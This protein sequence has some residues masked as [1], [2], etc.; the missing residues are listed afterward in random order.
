MKKFILFALI[1]LF[2][3]SCASSYVKISPETIN[4]TSSD[5][6]DS[7]KVEYKYG[8][9]QKKY[10]KKEYKKGIKVIAIKVTNN[11]ER[12]IT[13][14][15]NLNFT[16]ANGEAFYLL[17]DKDIFKPL[18][19]NVA[20]Y[21]LYLLLTPINFYTYETN[22]YGQ[23]E[24]TSSTPIGLVVGPGVTA[25]N[26]ITAASANKKFKTE[27]AEY[28]LVGKTIKTGE[29]IHGIIGVREQGF[30]NINIE[31]KD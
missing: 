3:T 31:L 10:A 1:S 17:E 15:Q 4:Y 12:D 13:V 2:L 16:K 28:N 24:T 27:I 29:T 26:T 11:S 6:K 5:K 9:L 8:V 30:Y 23:T 19:Q 18:R 7:V 14:G 21:L 20:T 22:Q 25:I